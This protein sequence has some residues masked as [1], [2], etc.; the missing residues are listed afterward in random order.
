MPSVKPLRHP[1]A[2]HGIYRITRP[3]S[4]RVCA[5]PER[6]T[7][8]GPDED[9]QISWQ[10]PCEDQAPS[11]QF[12]GEKLETE[13]LEMEGI[14]RITRPWNGR[15]CASVCVCVCWLKPFWLK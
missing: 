7:T 8:S 3:W 13:K 14:Y 4:G 5:A 2:I 9:Q 10:V 12:P 6:L 15:V 11:W 1:Q